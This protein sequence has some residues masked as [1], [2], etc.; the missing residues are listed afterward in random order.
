MVEEYRTLAFTKTA[1]A[2]A[3]KMGTLLHALQTVL[4]TPVVVGMSQTAAARPTQ[5]T[6]RHAK[7]PGHLQYDDKGNGSARLRN[8]TYTA[9]TAAGAQASPQKYIYS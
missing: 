8:S 9:P 3:T 1:Q 4:N 2:H 6:S 5:M 7:R